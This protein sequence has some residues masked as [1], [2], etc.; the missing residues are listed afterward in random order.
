MLELSESIN[1]WALFEKASVRP[2]VFIWNN[3][4]IKI[5]T[6][7]FVHTTHEGSALI[8]HFSVSAGGNFYKLGF[9]CSNLKWIL[10]AVE[11]DS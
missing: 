8:Y 10:E 5:E 2:F 3:R 6:I 11:D 9:D 7:N 1:V 4:K